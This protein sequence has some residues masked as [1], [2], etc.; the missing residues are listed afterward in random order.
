MNLIIICRKRRNFYLC[1]Y[2][3]AAS[4]ITTSNWWK[5]WWLFHWAQTVFVLL[6]SMG[7]CLPLCILYCH[8]GVDCDE[9]IE[10]FWCLGNMQM[11][12][13]QCC[14][15]WVNRSTSLLDNT[16]FSFVKHH[17]WLRIIMLSI[18][19]FFCLVTLGAS[20]PNRYSGRAEGL[21]RM[22]W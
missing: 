21:W 2:H 14:Q 17:F 15:K 22:R 1:R 20:L 11:T 16:A 10:Q 3:L 18:F 12:F 5:S 9:H 4:V 7:Y 8:T 13:S 19:H 6:F